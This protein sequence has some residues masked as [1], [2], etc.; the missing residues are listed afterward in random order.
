VIAVHQNKS[1]L[2]VHHEQSAIGVCKRSLEYEV[3]RTSLEQVFV[4]A[5]PQEWFIPEEVA[6]SCDVIRSVISNCKHRLM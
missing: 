3:I 5:V 1:R 2:G 4:T 6:G